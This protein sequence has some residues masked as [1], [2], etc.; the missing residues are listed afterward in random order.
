MIDLERISGLLSEIEKN[1]QSIKDELRKDNY[2]PKNKRSVEKSLKFLKIK[3]ALLEYYKEGSK[4][5]DLN[6]I[7]IMLG[8]LYSIDV[9]T[10]YL[11]KVLKVVFPEQRVKEGS[12]V[13]FL[14]EEIV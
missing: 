9:K 3:N 6:D 12:K 10:V 4:P 14:L 1:T 11:G 7:K 8:E 5:Y 13:Y 2:S